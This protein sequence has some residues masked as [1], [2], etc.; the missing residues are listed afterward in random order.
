[1]PIDSARSNK[2]A[3]LL[4]SIEIFVGGLSILEERSWRNGVTRKKKVFQYDE[5]KRSS[6]LRRST[7]I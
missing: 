6:R 3:L 5:N 2:I 1:M 4:A 7:P